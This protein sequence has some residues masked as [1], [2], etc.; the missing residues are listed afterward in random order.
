MGLF[1]DM[2]AKIRQIGAAKPKASDQ[3]RLAVQTEAAEIAANDARADVA[4]GESELHEAIV[5]AIDDGNEAR[6]EKARENLRR[7]REHADD[8]AHMAQAFRAK[9]DRARQD[10]ERT[11]R[12]RALSEAK[13]AAVSLRASLRRMTEASVELAAAGRDFY[14]ARDRMLLALPSDMKPS[15]IPT[16]LSNPTVYLKRHTGSRGPLY[17]EDA[18]RSGGSLE[19]L[20]SINEPALLLDDALVQ[21]LPDH[22]SPE[23][24]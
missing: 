20:A 7:L 14:A 12:A 23:A 21:I 8:L 3:E 4:R 11:Q 17:R 19:H 15:H 16:V 22:S 2:A 6:V 5:A 10:L 9:L 13:H 18:M 24:A 1:A